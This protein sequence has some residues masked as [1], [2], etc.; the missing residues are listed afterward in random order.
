MLLL[1]SRFETRADANGNLLLISQQERLRWSPELIH[2]GLHE[3]G[4]AASGNTLSEYHLLAGIAACHAVAP[5][6]EETDWRKILSYYEGLMVVSPSPIIAL[7]RAVAVS[8]VHGV[9]AGLRAVDE[10]EDRAQLR[11]YHL[12]PATYGVL[13][14]RTGDRTGAAIWYRRAL[15]MTTNEVERN[16]LISKLSELNKE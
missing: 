2:A 4:R 14:E 10:I 12:L 3:L 11:N 13:S 16:F 15:D 8:M 1:A 6:F 9:A 7:N 5:T